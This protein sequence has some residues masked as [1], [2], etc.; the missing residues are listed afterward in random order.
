VTETQSPDR[1][2]WPVP[3]MDGESLFSWLTRTGR[4]NVH[5]SPFTVLRRC[6][7]AYESRPYTALDGGVD[8]G[9]LAG[10]LGGNTEDVSS[11]MLSESETSG[12][13]VLDGI[14][15][16][17]DDL[18]TAV[19][20]FSPKSVRARKFHTMHAM[21]RMLP[22]C[23]ESWEYLK[24]TCSVCGQVQRWR[25]AWALD[26][27][28]GCSSPL[29]REVGVPVQHALRPALEALSRIVGSD[30]TE[31]RRIIDTLAP[32]LAAL[33]P[34]GVL[35]LTYSLAMVCEPKLPLERP[36]RLQLTDQRRL[37]SALAAA[38]NVLLEWP[39]A[40]DELV[41]ETISSA[42]FKAEERQSA[43]SR[44][45]RQRLVNMMQSRD[46]ATKL[47]QVIHLMVSVAD[48]Y[49]G[50]AKAP[51]SSNVLVK[52]AARRLGITEGEVS[53]G[54]ETGLLATR[55]GLSN[56]RILLNLDGAEIARLEQARRAR[57]GAHAV[58]LRLRL[59]AYAVE[60]LAATGL[61]EADDHPWLVARFGSPVITEEAV[62]AF[63]DKVLA[64]ASSSRGIAHRAD[65]ASV[66]R[67]FGGG[68]KPWETIFSMLLNRRLRFCVVGKD[69]NVG[70]ICIAG[71]DAAR[72][73]ALDPGESRNTFSQADA[74]EILNLLPKHGKGLS[75]LR[76]GSSD[77]NRWEIDGG[78]LDRAAKRYIS[79]PEL[80]ARTGL[81]PR[82]IRD[83]LLNLGCHPPTD[84]GWI[85]QSVL[86][87]L[88]KIA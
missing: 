16:R 9:H 85:R 11:R 28:D 21:Y 5:R 50:V 33:G 34:G 26:R 78:K 23:P 75:K 13:C 49:R 35:D 10:A 1:V 61:L 3:P 86:R 4:R 8:A 24:D 71:R 58:G 79:Y 56:G 32:D 59:P 76:V 77:S 25:H 70:T 87:Q 84:L 29:E 64:V 62:R 54:R 72:C 65:L 82:T 66:M 40:F 68:P 81:Y 60:R 46:R 27:C 52:P 57:L 63:K 19:R 48:T 74:L 22:F 12:F 38:W 45:A 80:V 42:R 55:I 43:P 15:V 51:S 36:A 17:R 83:A 47:P 69:V 18:V 20:R 31:R 53:R 88:T 14:D 73:M 6:G 39:A 44:A 41:C 37:A 2:M 30:R 7:L 67:R